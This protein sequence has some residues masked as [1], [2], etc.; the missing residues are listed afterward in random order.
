MNAGDD[1]EAPDPG[2]FYQMTTLHQTLASL[3][4]D[5]GAPNTI[6][7]AAPAAAPTL[8]VQENEV[9]VAGST[10]VDV[11]DTADEVADDDADGESAAN[12]AKPHPKPGVVCAGLAC[13]DM[14]LLG[15]TKTKVSERDSEGRRG[16]M[17]AA[18]YPNLAFS[19]RARVLPHC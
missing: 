17:I 16:E 1:D 6:P 8:E 18:T 14:Q 10:G 2:F 9:V 5:I 4:A 15:A 7:A 13:L 3:A 12:D 11:D 19:L